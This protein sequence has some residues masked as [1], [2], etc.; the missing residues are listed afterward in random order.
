MASFSAS[1]AFFSASFCAFSASFAFFSASFCAF[2]ASLSTFGAKD[3]DSTSFGS[4]FSKGGFGTKDS[5]SASVSA[6]VSTSFGKAGFGSS[7]ALATSDAKRS[8]VS[9]STS[10]T[11]F[12]F[13]GRPFFKAISFGSFSAFGRPRLPSFCSSKWISSIFLPILDA[14]SLTSSSVTFIFFMIFLYATT[15]FPSLSTYS[16]K[17]TFILSSIVPYF[18]TPLS[19]FEQYFL[20]ITVFSHCVYKPWFFTR[21]SQQPSTFTPENGITILLLIT[22]F[23]LLFSFFLYSMFKP[24]IPSSYE[25]PYFSLQYFITPDATFF[26]N[27]IMLSFIITFIIFNI[28]LLILLLIPYPLPFLSVSIFFILHSFLY[29]PFYIC[30]EPRFP[31]D[32]SF[33]IYCIV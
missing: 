20:S 19:H 29:S 28:L 31:Y 12:D 6:S 2:R 23:S 32:P 15:L 13:L 9:P 27:T 16:I 14:S 21:L 17:P 18:S 4:T 24:F 1:F 10:T 11:F 22:F 5:V 30:R 7:F 33:I 25:K 26:P 3:S 8:S